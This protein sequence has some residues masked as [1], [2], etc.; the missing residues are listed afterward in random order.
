MQITV[1]QDLRVRRFD[2]RVPTP[3]LGKR[4]PRWELIRDFIIELNGK[5]LVVPKGYVFDG[6]SVPRFLWFIFPP[7]YSPAWRGSCVH[8][9]GLSHGYKKYPQEYWDSLL[10]EF[11]LHDGGSTF[12]AN[13]FK[14]AVSRAPRGGYRDHN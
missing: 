4:R 8:D 1:L 13:L 6:S 3:W 14:W 5:Q 11:I 12:V 9:Y 2:G 10:R 7:S